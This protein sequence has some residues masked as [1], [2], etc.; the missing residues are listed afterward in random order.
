MMKLFRKLTKEQFKILYSITRAYNNAETYDELLH[1][2][3]NNLSQIEKPILDIPNGRKLFWEIWEEFVV[4]LPYFFSEK[5][6]LSKRLEIF[7]ERKGYTLI[8]V[9]LANGTDCSVF[10]Q[11]KNGELIPF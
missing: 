8:G 9:D 3:A 10:G 6:N 7:K 11:L 2:V 1:V 5:P 4:V